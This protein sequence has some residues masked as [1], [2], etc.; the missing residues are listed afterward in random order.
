MRHGDRRAREHL[1]LRVGDVTD[2]RRGAGLRAGGEAA[3]RAETRQ[4]EQR[5]SVLRDTTGRRV[6]RPPPGSQTGHN[7]VRPWEQRVRTQRLHYHPVMQGLKWT[8]VRAHVKRG[9]RWFVVRDADGRRRGPAGRRS[10]R[11][12]DRAWIWSPSMPRCWAATA[13]RSTTSGL[14]TSGWRST[15]A[16]GA[17]CLHSMF[18]RRR[19]KRLPPPPRGERISRSNEARRCR[20]GDRR[21]G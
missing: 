15:A 5:R 9:M 13:P 17:S 2:Q 16:S 10:S 1:L 19:G 3:E 11:L 21:G 7:A 8:V 14:M 20:P 12:F 18:R 6:S 4:R